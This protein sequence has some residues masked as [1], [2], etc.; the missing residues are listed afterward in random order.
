MRQPPCPPLVGNATGRDCKRVQAICPQCPRPAPAKWGRRFDRYVD[1]SA[2][3]CLV[4]PTVP[5]V[6][7]EKVMGEGSA[8]RV[9]GEVEI[10][11]RGKF[12]LMQVYISEVDPR[13]FTGP[14]QLWFLRVKSARDFARLTSCGIGS[15]RYT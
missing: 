4:V 11:L 5:V 7:T 12:Q 6:P 8:A 3:L 13:R 10:F 15:Q 2:A 1:D 9:G 14:P